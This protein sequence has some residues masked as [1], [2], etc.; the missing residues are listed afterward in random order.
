[1]TAVGST[2]TPYVTSGNA[3]DFSS[4]ELI[5][6]TGVIGQHGKINDVYTTTYPALID[7]DVPSRVTSSV[8][9][10]KVVLDRL[11]TI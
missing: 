9:S 5:P 2:T 7:V 10:K 1:M 11:E 3:S 6:V 8:S 4:S